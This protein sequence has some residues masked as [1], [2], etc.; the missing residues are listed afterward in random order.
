MHGT[1]SDGSCTLKIG[2]FSKTNKCFIVT[3]GS[4]NRDS[5]TKSVIPHIFENHKREQ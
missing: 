1:F 5:P 4:F 3:T 2:N